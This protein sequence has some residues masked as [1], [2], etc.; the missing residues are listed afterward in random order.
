MVAGRQV[1]G[2]LEAQVLNDLQKYEYRII[3]GICLQK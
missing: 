1:R 3:R 2:T